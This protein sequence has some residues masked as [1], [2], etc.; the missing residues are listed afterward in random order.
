MKSCSSTQIALHMGGLI[1]RYNI[2]FLITSICLRKSSDVTMNK[3]TCTFYRCVYL[4]QDV[5]F[6]QDLC[7]IPLLQGLLKGACFLYKIEG[8]L[9]RRRAIF[10][11]RRSFHQIFTSYRLRLYRR[12]MDPVPQFSDHCSNASWML[13]DLPCLCYNICFYTDDTCYAL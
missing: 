13:C 11:A 1:L 6:L 8:I 5:P 3:I 4:L 12:K 9:R 10:S 2:I 7:V